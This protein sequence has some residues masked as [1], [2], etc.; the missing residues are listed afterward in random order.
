MRSFLT[1]LCTLTVGLMVAACQ[2]DSGKSA[3][4]KSAENRDRNQSLAVQQVPVPRIENFLVRQYVAD[5]M[6]R[7]DAPG[8]DWYTYLWTPMGQPLGYY[9]GTKPVSVCTF[10]SPT[11]KR[12]RVDVGQYNGEVL[13]PASGADGVHYGSGGGGCDTMF[14]FDKSTDALI[15]I[16]GTMARQTFDA[17]LA[18]D[19]PKLTFKTAE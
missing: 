17:P 16:A 14:M 15:E 11:V 13:G 9:V 2:P 6:K 1:L 19:V 3:D 10:L 4:Q 8:K 18:I 5:Y 12:W 7:M